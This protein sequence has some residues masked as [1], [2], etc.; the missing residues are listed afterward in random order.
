MAIR[1]LH[2]IET[3]LGMGGMENGVV[4]LIRRM[5][6]GRFEHVVCVIRSLGVL[7]E[8]IPQDRVKLIC[9]GHTASGFR[10]VAPELGRLVGAVKRDIVHCGSRGTYEESFAG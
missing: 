10:F 4:N 5:D 2:V 7:S 9:R 6:P 8:A 1:I 3:M